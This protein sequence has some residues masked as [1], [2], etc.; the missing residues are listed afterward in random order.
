MQ[1]SYVLGVDFGTDSVRALVV[2]SDDGSELG[3]AVAPFT[4]WSQGL[5]CSPSANRFRQHPL[6]HLQALERAVTEA[7]DICPSNTAEHVRGVG[8]DTTGSS[9]GPVDSNGVALGL[10]P[11]FEND[12][13]AL[14][15]LWK[16]HTAV[17]EA[18]EINELA[19]GWGGTDYTL[20]SGGVYSS[21]WFWSKILHV[22][23]S[24]TRVRQAAFSWME[25]C[26]W[27]CWTITGGG[28]PRKAPRSRCAAGHKAMW[29]A[30]WDGLPSQEFL[31]RLDPLLDGIRDKLYTQTITS[32][33]PAGALCPQWAARL[34]LPPGIPVAVGAFDAHMGAVGAGIVP[35]ALTKVIGTSTCD[36]L[37]APAGDVG[38]RAV[39]GI[40]GQVDGSVI[41]GM[42]GMEAG[43]S[44][45]GDVFAWLRGLLLWP[46]DEILPGV[47]G[48]SEAQAAEIAGQLKGRIY[49][50]LTR[51]A[52]ALAPEDTT[53]LALDWLNGR[54]TPD[55]DQRLT[56]AL[57]GLGLGTNPPRLFRALVES[58]AYG[59][60][61]IAE[62]FETEGVKIE[63]VI[64][65][66]GVATQSAF[67]MQT[68]ADVMGR[69]ISIAASE[70]A[71]ALGAAMF[72]AAAAGLYDG[73]LSAQKAM[74][75]GFSAEF[76]PRPQYVEIYEILY[77]RYLKLG[78]F[79]EAE[80]DR[81]GQ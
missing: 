25:H 20:Y 64:A 59:A 46:L 37:V 1:N 21:E 40:C 18:A 66:G 44:A 4:R 27:L 43:Q 11:E 19:H 14:F 79:I 42:V 53:V 10:L 35:Y 73:V 69:R 58:T 74:S 68:V 7:L 51:Q 17:G 61:R 6:D 26:D 60:R 45:F 62:R 22:L 80:T 9:P 70:Q 24:S 55:A 16:D 63:Q 50:E 15:V 71:C 41:P 23:R 67:V 56:G 2:D 31:S 65:L 12:P 39:S 49:G 5:F 57:T 48:I 75:A 3:S 28:D 77:Q 38:G 13:D 33:K 34:G 8:V 32:D 76:L 54:R 81:S 78:D 29:N 36:M 30:S 52:Q 47:E 72:A